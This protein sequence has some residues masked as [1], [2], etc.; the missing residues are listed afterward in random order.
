MDGGAM[1]L[2]SLDGTSVIVSSEQ[3][4]MGSVTFGL[5]LGNKLGIG[6]SLKALSSTLIGS[7]NALTFAFDAGAF[8]KGL[9]MEE[10][11]A[12]ISILNLGTG[13][14]YL[15]TTE[16]LPFVIQGGVS[17]LVNGLAQ[18][19]VVVVAMDGV[20][21]GDGKM[22]KLGIEGNYQEYAVRIGVPFLSTDDQSFSFGLGYRME[23]QYIFDYGVSF[24]KSLGLTHRISVGILLDDTAGSRTKKRKTE[25]NQGYTPGSGNVKGNASTP[26]PVKE[27]PQAKPV[28]K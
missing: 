13:L 6:A 2:N 26:I 25:N 19:L 1:D 17:Y 10:L 7:K 20:I 27:S 5:P 9:F 18:D 3:D 11:N 23:E 21:N 12:G 24:G 8:Y 16:S 28:V 4:I 14:K 15:D 22:V